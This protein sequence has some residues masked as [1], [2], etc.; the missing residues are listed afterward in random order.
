MLIDDIIKADKCKRLYSLS[1][2]CRHVIAFHVLKTISNSAVASFCSSKIKCQVSIVYKMIINIIMSR[3]MHY[4]LKIIRNFIHSVFSLNLLVVPISIFLISIYNKQNN[5]ILKKL[6]KSLNSDLSSS[7]G[8]GRLFLWKN[9]IQ[10]FLDNTEQT[11]N[12]K[13]HKTSIV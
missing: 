12:M 5:F 10:I 6:H 11:G 4:Q 8:I 13:K 9:S 1:V 3:K 2:R 7:V